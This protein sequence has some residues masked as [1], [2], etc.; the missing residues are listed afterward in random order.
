MM[1]ARKTSR[2]FD[3]P[4]TTP[5]SDS[6]AMDATDQFHV[7]VVVPDLDGELARLT[8]L[9]G[10]EWGDEVDVPVMVRFPSGEQEVR[11]RFRYSLDE[12]RLELIQQQPGTLW[13]PVE[14]SGL[15]HLGFWSDDLVA[16]GA[17]LTASGYS[18][19]AEGVDDAGVVNWAYYAA[20][21]GPRVELIDRALEPMLE[22]LYRRH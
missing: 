21:S 10:Y 2:E 19:Q 20:P 17:V 9:L 3:A 6:G 15:H 16:D 5:M 13:M 12:P 22:L 11:F 14:E 7:G 1:R 8:G 18:M 4:S